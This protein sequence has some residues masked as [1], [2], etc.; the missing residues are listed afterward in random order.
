VLNFNSADK[1]RSEMRLL[2]YGGI[3]L[4]RRFSDSIP[5]SS[6]DIL[7]THRKQSAT[8][9]QTHPLK[10]KKCCRFSMVEDRPP[11]LSSSP[12]SAL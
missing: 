4:Q 12:P 3:L 7:R 10:Q 11:V 5:R 9:N 2:N 6:L 1:R 8:G